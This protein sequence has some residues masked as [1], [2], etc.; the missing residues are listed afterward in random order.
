MGGLVSSSAHEGEREREMRCVYVC[1]WRSADEKRMLVK[2]CSVYIKVDCCS[3]I[4]PMCRV[5][6]CVRAL[7][8]YA[9]ACVY[10][11]VRVCVCAAGWAGSALGVLPLPREPLKQ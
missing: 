8:L 2:E 11:C 7:W 3:V 1:A 9:C 10:A 5:R 6:A 4:A